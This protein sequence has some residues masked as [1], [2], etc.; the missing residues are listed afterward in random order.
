MVAGA[1]MELTAYARWNE[2]QWRFLERL[3]ELVRTGRSVD[4][5][6]SLEDGE[7]WGDY[8]RAMLEIAR[9]DVTTLVRLVPIA[10][11]ARRLID[12][13]GSHAFL[14]A[15]IC[16]RH[17]PLRSTVIDLPPALEH[18]RVLAGEGGYAELVDFV[19]G[20]LRYDD[21]E[22]PTPS[23]SRTCSTT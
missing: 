3:N 2:T 22:G 6:E 13:G 15:A 16:R 12:L 21:F 10:A 11:W 7:V 19:A 9:L 20:D 1:P 18:A 5:H 4:F 23:F 17:P 14:G 8:Q